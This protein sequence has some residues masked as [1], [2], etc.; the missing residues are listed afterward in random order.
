M[1]LLVH[2]EVGSLH[3]CICAEHA[4]LLA[5]AMGFDQ[6]SDFWNKPILIASDCKGLVSQFH[7]HVQNLCATGVILEEFQHKLMQTN[8]V[9]IVYNHR[10]TNMA[11][12]YLALIVAKLTSG[13]VWFK[14]AHPSV[15][16]ILHS[17]ICMV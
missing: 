1:R 14:P 8:G 16:D 10:Q 5:M 9:S 3:A 12:H 7:Q 17:R 6:T 15:F 4:E 13:I 2:N 11:A